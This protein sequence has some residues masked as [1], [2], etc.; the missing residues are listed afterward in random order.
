[1][2]NYYFSLQGVSPDGPSR[3]AEGGVY[4]SEALLFVISDVGF[5]NALK[6]LI[7]ATRSND[8]EI[9]RI[10]SAGSPNA[11][12]PDVFPFPHD[13]EAMMEDAEKSGE[14]CVRDGD[15]YGPLTDKLSGVTLGF[16]DVFDPSRVKEGELYEG[17]IVAF[18]IKGA[19]HMALEG[20]VLRCET[21]NLTLK[22]IDGMSDA[23]FCDPDVLR[24]IL[25]IDA[26]KYSLARGQLCWGTSHSYEREVEDKEM[27]TAPR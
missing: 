10:V 3:V 25:A 13:L 17:E 26:N 20:L 6:A 18:A 19:P 5:A 12:D 7:A 11:F 2:N 16:A 27:P 21:E 4:G 23:V 8:F 22:G 9:E 14:I 1:M 15:M 24:E